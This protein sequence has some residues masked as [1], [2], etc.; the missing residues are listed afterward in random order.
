M[1]SSDVLP[2]SD[3]CSAA[4]EVVGTFRD[5]DTGGFV[6][7]LTGYVP[8]KLYGERVLFESVNNTV[9][10]RRVECKWL[11]DTKV[12]SECKG[13]FYRDANGEKIKGKDSVLVWGTLVN[14]TQVDENLVKVGAYYL[15]IRL[16]K[17]QQVLWPQTM[18]STAPL[19]ASSSGSQTVRILLLA[20]ESAGEYRLT[21]TVAGGWGSQLVLEA[22]ATSPSLASFLKEKQ[23]HCIDVPASALQN[24]EFK[25]QYHNK[26]GLWNKIQNLFHDALDWEYGGVGNNRTIKFGCQASTLYMYFGS[27]EPSEDQVVEFI[28]VALSGASMQDMNL[29]INKVEEVKQ[30]VLHV[31]CQQTTRAPEDV[32]FKKCLHRALSEVLMILSQQK[33]CGGLYMWL[34]VL[35][36]E[37]KCNLKGLQPVV[38]LELLSLI[39][40]W[41]SAVMQHVVLQ[42][43]VHEVAKNI[44]LEEPR[45]PPRFLKQWLQAALQMVVNG[46]ASA[47]DVGQLKQFAA[48]MP[49]ACLPDDCSPE[50]GDI[51]LQR[52][53]SENI[54]SAFMVALARARAPATVWRAANHFLDHIDRRDVGQACVRIALEEALAYSVSG[55]SNSW[56]DWSHIVCG[57]DSLLDRLAENSFDGCLQDRLT[58]LIQQHLGRWSGWRIF[59]P[60]QPSTKGAGILA[61][62]LTAE[63]GRAC[64]VVFQDQSEFAWLRLAAD[65]QCQDAVPGQVLRGWTCQVHVEEPV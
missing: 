14:G 22:E 36:Q 5:S 41:P 35:E 38:R 47:Q 55:S 52:A 10:W 27:P 34:A 19:L 37:I 48:R 49:D 18:A 13:I 57:L 23:V 29:A 25:F 40:V 1:Q 20:P 2:L 46:A 58:K 65:V 61:R 12:Q 28:K 56:M 11:V 7:I 30:S 33:P 17:L 43:R 24:A 3:F 9:I 31:S 63:P 26:E 60:N 21:G 51:S 8:M 39:S 4:C 32:C 64:A 50:W 59:I 15:P 16:E 44:L 62:A 6:Q 42:N 54:E 53:R 45:A